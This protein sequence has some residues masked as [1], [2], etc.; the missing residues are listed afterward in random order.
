MQLQVADARN[1]LDVAARLCL[2]GLVAVPVTTVLLM[3]YDLWLLVPLGCYLFA[4]ASY[5]SAIAGAKRFGD[6]LAV[7]F[8]LY[9][10]RLWP[11]YCR[12]CSWERGWKGT[13]GNAS[14]T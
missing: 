5:R 11:R 9:H 13:N 8:D 3:R 12:P 14:D 2:L 6:V 4:W 7:V 1:Q 10:M